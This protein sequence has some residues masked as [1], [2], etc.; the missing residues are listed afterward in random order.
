MK[1][2]KKSRKFKVHFRLEVYDG[3]NE[4]RER[5]NRDVKGTDF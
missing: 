5:S 3:Y 1:S 4:T 2:E